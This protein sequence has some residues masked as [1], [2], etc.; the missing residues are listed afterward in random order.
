MKSKAL[1]LCVQKVS[2]FSSCRYLG[3]QTQKLY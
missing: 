2:R 1:Q 3:L